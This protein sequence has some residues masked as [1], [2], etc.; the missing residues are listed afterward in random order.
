MAVIAAAREEALDQAAAG[1]DLERDGSQ[2]A[3]STGEMAR[4]PGCAVD[5]RPTQLPWQPRDAQSG[6][7]GSRNCEETCRW[8]STPR[9]RINQALHTGAARSLLSSPRWGLGPASPEPRRSS[10]QDF[11]LGRL[12]DAEY[13]RALPAPSPSTSMPWK[14][15]GGCAAQDACHRIFLA[16]V[17]AAGRMGNTH[18]LQGWRL[19]RSGLEDGRQRRPPGRPR[20]MAE[21]L[22]RSSA[23]PRSNSH[24]ATGGHGT[25]R[26]GARSEPCGRSA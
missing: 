5:R 23:A 18:R 9:G 26:P 11:F 20:P 3:S 13:A 1:Q 22:P 25:H 10:M 19:G 2:A 12:A 4:S 21:S 24:G 15:A 14:L 8:P 16:L 7:G 17:K 6:R